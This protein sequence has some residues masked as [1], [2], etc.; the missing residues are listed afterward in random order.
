MSIDFRKIQTCQPTL[1]K[2]E[3]IESVTDYKYL[4]IVLD[5]KLKWDTWTDLV[6]TKTQ[7]RMY[8]LAKLLSFNVHN[9]TCYDGM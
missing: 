8:F 6:N 4:G 2:G 9:S 3:P 1:I 7:Q 5:H